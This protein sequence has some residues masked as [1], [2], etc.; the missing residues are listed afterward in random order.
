MDTI[1]FGK[2][3]I[4]VVDDEKSIRDMLSRHFRF[5]GY[6]VDTSEN[7]K[8]ALAQMALKRYLV[9]ISD[10]NMP[11]MDGTELLHRIRSEYPMTHVIMITGYVTME[12]VLSC[13]RHGADTCIFKPIE[14]MSELENAVET[15]VGQLNRWQ[16]KLKALIKMKP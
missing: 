1:D 3:T 15:A 5:L 7:G 13:M 4:L 6:D 12:N 8:D 9:V 11:V 14:D 10:I 2:P 16:E